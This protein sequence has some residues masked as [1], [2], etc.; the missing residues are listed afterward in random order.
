MTLRDPYLTRGQLVQTQVG[1]RKTL[2]TISLRDQTSRAAGSS[3][4]FM[5]RS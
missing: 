5:K 3:L 4:T 1:K 2:I